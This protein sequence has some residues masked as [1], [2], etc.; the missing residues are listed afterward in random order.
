MKDRSSRP[1]VGVLAFVTDRSM[2]LLELAQE[3]E[4]RGFDAL[5]LP[6]H[7]HIP[8]S[9]AEAFPDGEM[10][11]RYRRTLDPYVALAVVAARTGLAIGTCISLVAQHDPITLAKTVATLDLVS[12][13]R[14]TLGVG[15]GWNVDELAN[16]GRDPSRRRGIVTE[17]VALMRSL[18]RDELAEFRGEHATLAPS[19]A[20][21][22][23]SAEAAVPVLLGCA[24]TARGFESVVGWADGWIPGGDDPELLAGWMVDLRTR[25][26]AARRPGS[27]VV[28][29]MRTV[30]DDATLAR[31]LDR[32]RSLG[33]DQ[34]VLDVQALSR[35]ELP[36][37]LDRYADVVRDV[38]GEASASP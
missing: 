10:P 28:W 8:L 3:V 1:D 34:V 13:G 38:L 30:V 2:P 29:A 7:T 18:W 22:K 5:V 37:V 4:A 35:E 14:F 6:E 25:W 17:H 33:V 21:P 9:S 24:P 32:Y 36:A 15:Y 23:P 31:H 16:H 12:G 26:E 19:W 27:P 11:E 20:W